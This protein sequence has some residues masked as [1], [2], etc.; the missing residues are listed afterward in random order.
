MLLASAVLLVV[1][2]GA[3]VV[4]AVRLFFATDRA[5]LD[6]ERVV[7]RQRAWVTERAVFLAS[8]SRI[9][10]GVQAGTEAVVFGSAVTRAGHRAIAAIP[11]GIMKAIPATR[12][13]GR[14][15]QKA[16]DEAAARM[17]GGIE[18]MSSRIAEGVRLRLTGD[19]QWDPNRELENAEDEVLEVEFE[20]VDEVDPD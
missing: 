20:V 1:V 18:S 14:R 8:R 16:H 2:A 6:G 5:L 19:R 17:Y 10:D 3:L 4:L 13:R 7:R 12:D 9:A 15:A 11:F